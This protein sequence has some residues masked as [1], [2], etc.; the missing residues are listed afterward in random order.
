VRR[1]AG[2]Y[3]SD[4]VTLVWADGAIVDKVLRVI[5]RAGPAT[6]LAAPDVFYFAN[7]AGEVD[8]PGALYPSVGRI[9]AEDVI[10]VRSALSPRPAP[11]TS[12][13]DVN[14][15]GRVNAADLALVRARLH[16]GPYPLGNPVSSLP[17]HAPT[18]LSPAPVRA[19]AVAAERAGR[20]T[21]GR[22]SLRPPA[23]RPGRP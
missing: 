16:H 12:A 15:D 8:V 7:V 2:R 17:P 11:V 13:A 23:W 5:A 21:H 4:R 19:A 1:G 3:G 18:D 9:D 20:V 6:G 14:H 22:T 10:L